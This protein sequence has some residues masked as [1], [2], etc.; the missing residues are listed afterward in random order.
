M[1]QFKFS[2]TLKSNEFTIDVNVPVISFTDEK[3]QVFYCPALDLGGYGDNDNEARDSFQVVLEEFLTYTIHKNTLISELK[4]LGWTVR[5]NKR[6][7]MIPPEMSD[8]LRDNE[9]FTNIFKL[10]NYCIQFR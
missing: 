1:S 7:P 2:G 8:L 3:S 10:R 4:R 5:K 9:N 6:K